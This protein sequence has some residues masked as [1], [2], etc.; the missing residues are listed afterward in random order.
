MHTCIY[1]FFQFTDKGLT[2]RKDGSYLINL[3]QPDPEKAEQA[4]NCFVDDLQRCEAL[5]IQLYNFH[6]GSALS[7]PRPEAIVSWSYVCSKD[8][9]Y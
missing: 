9:T 6:P 1:I 2:Q 8:I 3:A 4:L 7:F 5:G